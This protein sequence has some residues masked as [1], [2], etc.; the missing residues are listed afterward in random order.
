MCTCIHKR[1]TYSSTV[2]FEGF[3]FGTAFLVNFGLS[4]LG[5]L[6]DGL[7]GL[8]FLVLVSFFFEAGAGLGDATGL[9]PWVFFFLG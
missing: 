7:L 8:A 5:G 1:K 6:M 2:R 3:F 9:F 4:F